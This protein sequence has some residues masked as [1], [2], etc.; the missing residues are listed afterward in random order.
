MHCLKQPDSF[1][2]WFLKTFSYQALQTLYCYQTFHN[3]S[4]HS[5]TPYRPWPTLLRSQG[6]KPYASLKAF[7]SASL[8]QILT[9]FSTKFYPTWVAPHSQCRILYQGLF[10]YDEDSLSV[11]PEYIL[12]TAKNNLGASKTSAVSASSKTI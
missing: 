2:I 10:C 11:S 6:L 8:I 5:M 4:I 9:A 1:C 3:P 12:S 7:I